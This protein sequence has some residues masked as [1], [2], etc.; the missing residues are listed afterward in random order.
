MT[1]LDANTEIVITRNGTNNNAIIAELD[2]IEEIVINSRNT[3]AN[4]RGEGSTGL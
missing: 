3:T 4:K 1:G 2:N